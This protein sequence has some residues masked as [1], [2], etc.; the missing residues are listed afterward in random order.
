MKRWNKTFHVDGIQK[1]SGIG[2]LISDKT[3][4]KFKK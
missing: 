3:D 4:F 1:K 2:I